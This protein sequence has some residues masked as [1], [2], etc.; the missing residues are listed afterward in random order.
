MKTK[1]NLIA[2]WALVA[3]GSSASCATLYVDL[4]SSNPTAPY[5]SWTTAARVIQDAVDAGA[6]GDEVVVT[7]GLYASGGRA[8][9]TNLLANRVVVDK[10][11]TL[12]SAN[13]PQF[14]II[15]GHQATNN[16]IESGAFRC[17]YL[18]SGAN[19]S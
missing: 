15:E 13:G 17:V 19:L 9:G 10:P 3:S 5:T 7:N 16:D 2:A 12:R 4:N 14:T 11:L 8:V 1:A 18:S 6:A